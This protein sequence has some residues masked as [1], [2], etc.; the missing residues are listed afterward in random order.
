MLAPDTTLKQVKN[1]QYS[2][3]DQIGKGF[4]SQVFRG[5]QSCYE[6]RNLNNGQSVAIKVINLRSINTEV[7]KMLLGNELRALRQLQHDNIIQTYDICQTTS[8]VYIITEYCNQGDLSSQIRLK[9]SIHQASRRK[10]FGGRSHAVLPAD[11]QWAERDVCS[12]H[13]PQ[14]SQ[15]C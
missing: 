8:N 6:G 1:F 4:S 2:E 13:P 14:G 10:V 3:T 12:R 9:G 15:D 5:T 7:E 11:C